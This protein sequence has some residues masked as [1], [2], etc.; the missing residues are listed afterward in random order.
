MNTTNPFDEI[1]Q[2]LGRT[3]FAGGRTWGRD[4]RA[5]DIDVAEYDDEFVV[6]ADL[7]GFDR[8]EI[9]VRASGDRLTI[10]GERDTEREDGDRRYLRRERRHES[11]TRT[12]E[13]PATAVLEDATAT[14]RH[15]VLTVTV[16]LDAVDADEG[17]RIDVN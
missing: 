14:Y 1:E 10:S 5:A 15:G 11:V 17:H 2:F 13:L 6:M 16:P 3:P 8:E 12:I 9:D 7:P 4:L